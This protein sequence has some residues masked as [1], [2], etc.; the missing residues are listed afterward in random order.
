MYTINLPIPIAIFV[1]LFLPC[2]IFHVV[3]RR[4]PYVIQIKT[5]SILP[6]MLY[7]I[8]V[9]LCLMGVAA[10]LASLFWL[11]NPS[12][13]ETANGFIVFACFAIGAAY[14]YMVL[15]N[16]HQMEFEREE[17]TDALPLADQQHVLELHF[18]PSLFKQ[19][20]V[21][22][23]LVKELNF[24]ENASQRYMNST[25]DFTDGGEL[26][27]AYAVRIQDVWHFY[28]QSINSPFVPSFLHEIVFIGLVRQTVNDN[29]KHKRRE[30]EQTLLKWLPDDYE[31]NVDFEDWTTIIEER[32][33]VLSY[34][35][36]LHMDWKI[37]MSKTE[38]DFVV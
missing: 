5:D 36:D 3:T 38:R 26:F 12:W 16:G 18:A 19:P 24:M 14:V 2:V 15:A 10:L 9:S 21:T 4:T 22:E 23:R 32:S 20:F 17:D 34:F 27:Y 33:E 37:R 30:L 7:F 31:R 11:C 35:C 28:Y 6:T 1:V 8:R 25:D 13:G 29:E